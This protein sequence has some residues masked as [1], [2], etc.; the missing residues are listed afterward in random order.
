MVRLDEGVPVQI[1]AVRILRVKVGIVERFSRNK[2]ATRRARARHGLIAAADADGRPALITV[3]RRNAPSADEG[4]EYRM[5]IGA[6]GPALAD[7]Q[8]VHIAQGI[9]VRAIGAADD[10]LGIGGVDVLTI[11]TDQSL[12]ERIGSHQPEPLGITLLEADFQTIVGAVSGLRSHRAEAAVLRE[13]AKRLLQLQRLGEAGIG[14]LESRRHN[15][16]VVDDCADGACEQRAVDREVL[17]VELIEVQAALKNLDPVIG[18]E[19]G[20]QHGGRRKAVLHRQVIVGV[21]PRL[22]GFRRLVRHAAVDAQSRIYLGRT[23]AFD[24][25]AE[26][27]E[28]VFLRKGDA[29]R[30]VVRDRAE[31]AAEALDTG[32]SVIVLPDDIPHDRAAAAD[33]RLR[34]ELISET[35]PRGEGVFAYIDENRIVLAREFE[36]AQNA[37]GRRIRDGRIE[38]AVPQ[39][40]FPARNAKVVAKSRVDR[41]P[42]RQLKVVLNVPGVIFVAEV[43][44]GAEIERAAAR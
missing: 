32:V 25:R 37:A 17:R 22:A 14:Q 7:R 2:V 6:E 15:D 18:V 33:H 11:L 39:L 38:V 44:V 34:V 9:D 28:A 21:I 5:Y 41:K 20:P 4:V 31:A 40:G 8:I 19:T 10:F 43:Y 35:Q 12:R 16:R 27:V 3:N 30:Q 42:A 26:I 24:Q 1:A 13:R 29:V 36:R 23:L